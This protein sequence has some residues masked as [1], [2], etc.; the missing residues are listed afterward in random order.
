MHL[1]SDK[2]EQNANVSYEKD[3]NPMDYITLGDYK[4]MKVSLAVSQDDIQ[5]EID[6]I[7]EEYTSYKKMSGVVKMGDMIHATFDGYIDGKR[8]DSTC[9]SDYIHIGSG[10]WLPGFEDAIIGVKTGDNKKFTLDIP[11][12][13]YG[14]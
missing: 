10:E 3:F 4:G 13:T 1:T 6:S 14:D 11:E 2:S 8:A 12:G 5:S 7:L 9:G